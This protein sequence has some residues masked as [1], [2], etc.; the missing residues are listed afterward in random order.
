M[1]KQ[2]VNVNVFLSSDI[3]FIYAAVIENINIKNY[4]QNI[5]HIYNISHIVDGVIIYFISADSYLFFFI[6]LILIKSPIGRQ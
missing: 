1:C 2:S 6:R 4:R 3:F 5:M